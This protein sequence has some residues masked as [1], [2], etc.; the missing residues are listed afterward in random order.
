M[1]HGARKRATPTSEFTKWL[2]RGS[3]DMRDMHGHP[4]H[5]GIVLRPS[6]KHPCLAQTTMPSSAKHLLLLC[7]PFSLLACEVPVV[8]VASSIPARSSSITLSSAPAV[9]AVRRSSTSSS[10]HECVCV[11][12][13]AVLWRCVAQGLRCSTPPELL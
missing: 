6:W 8:D 3:R 5:P 7:F 2:R 11:C 12:V 4:H 1:T 9:F 13:C 10:P